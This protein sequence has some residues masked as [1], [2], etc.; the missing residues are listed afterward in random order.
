MQDLAWFKK[1]IGQRIY[2]DSAECPCH[3]C[4]DAV[5]D[6]LI[7]TDEVHAEYLYDI[8]NEFANDGYMLNYRDEK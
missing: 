4:Q 1:R 2:R 3:A 6:G 8:Q 5:K 7:I